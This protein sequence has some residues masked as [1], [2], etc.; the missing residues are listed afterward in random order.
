MACGTPVITSNLSSLPEVAGNAAILV[1]PYQIL[2]LTNAMQSL[3]KDQEKRSQ[4]I[5]RSLEQAKKFSWE[6]TGLETQAVLEQ[7]L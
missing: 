7:F 2:E 1:N 4:L 3:I 6:K 5:E